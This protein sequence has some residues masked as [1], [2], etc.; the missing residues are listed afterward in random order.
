MTTEHQRIYH[1]EYLREWR[2]RNPDY[3][4]DMS[5]IYRLRAKRHLCVGTDARGCL[6]TIPG[7]RLHCHFCAR[8]LA[9]A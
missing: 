9:L 8:T 1:R 7:D 4:R 3:H 6:V 2:K 5:R